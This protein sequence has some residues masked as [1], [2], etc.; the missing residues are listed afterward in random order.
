MAKCALQGYTVMCR[1]RR[2]TATQAPPGRA[3]RGC[4]ARRAS[5]DRYWHPA[6]HTTRKLT[7]RF[8]TRSWD[9]AG[10]LAT[11]DCGRHS[12]DQRMMQSRS[13]RSRCAGASRLS[14]ISQHITDSASASYRTR[15]CSATS[16]DRRRLRRVARIDFACDPGER[17]GDAR[18]GVASELP[19]A[20]GRAGR[21]RGVWYLVPDRRQ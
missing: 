16:R 13:P 15:R 11:T 14:A 19:C 21:G 4:D 18:R 2:H 20:L 8:E 10:D 3:R 9:A 6:A 1:A 17:A 5:D 7:R 12:F